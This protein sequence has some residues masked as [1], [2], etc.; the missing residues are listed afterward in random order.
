MDHAGAR[1]GGSDGDDSERVDRADSRTN[2][3]FSITEDCDL[4]SLVVLFEDDQ[5]N[6]DWDSIRFHLDSMRSKEELE[7]R[8]EWIKTTRDSVVS[9]FPPQ[10]LAGS[11][12]MVLTPRSCIGKRNTPSLLPISTTTEFEFNL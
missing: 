9:D 10:F 2:T 5:G 3:P 7:Q 8:L 6:I 11:T 12:P 1:V 4:V